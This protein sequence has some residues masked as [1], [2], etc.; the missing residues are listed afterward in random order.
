LAQLALGRMDAMTPPEYHVVE[1]NFVLGRHR[2]SPL[3]V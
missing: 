3:S 1:D 2:F